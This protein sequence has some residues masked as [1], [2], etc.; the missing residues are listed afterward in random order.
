MQHPN[1]QID[2]DKIEKDLF[3]AVSKMMKWDCSKIENL[4]KDFK[5]SLQTKIEQL[6]DQFT[7]NRPKQIEPY[8]Q[9]NIDV[10]AY[11]MH[12]HA[13]TMQ[14]MMSVCA[15]IPPNMFSHQ[16]RIRVLDIGAGTGA[17]LQGFLFWLHQV[18]PALRVE[19]D[20]LDQSLKVL[21]FAKNFLLSTTPYPE[22]IEIIPL[23]LKQEK[24]SSDA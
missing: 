22:K 1:V 20:L 16:K 21:T 9:A 13:A 19:A 11:A 3:L 12:F 6:S 5:K 14:R 23:D 24:L 17:A 18:Y 2:F 15:E 4:H 8:F 10:A 7:H